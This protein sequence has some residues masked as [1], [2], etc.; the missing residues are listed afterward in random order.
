MTIYT[1]FL[2]F[3]LSSITLIVLELLAAQQGM[4]AVETA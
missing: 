3:S 4:F 1:W 2:Y